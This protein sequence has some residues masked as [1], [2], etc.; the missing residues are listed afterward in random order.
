MFE[1]NKKLLQ[2]NRRNL[3][4]KLTPAEATLWTMINK[5][6]LGVR[7]LRQYSAGNYILDFY[8]PEYRLAIELDGEVHF[9]E[10]YIQKD[11]IRTQFLNNKDIRVLRFENFEV[12]KYPER[13]IQEIKR[14]LHSTE[15]PENILI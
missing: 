4:H 6:Q 9:D 11:K 3:R 8:C 14:F 5:Q 2:N 12:F 1:Y 10:H 7:F 15:N 13:T